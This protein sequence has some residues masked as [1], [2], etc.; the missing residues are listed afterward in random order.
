MSLFFFVYTIALLIVCIGVASICGATYIVTHSRR[1]LP[2]AGFFIFYFLELCEI[3][4]EEWLYHNV[5]VV[6]ASNYYDIY[7]PPLRIALGA[8]IL[9]C[10][11]AVVLNM[12]DVR[13]KKFIIYPTIAIV[14][15]QTAILL[16]MPYGPFRQWMFFTMRQVSLYACLGYAYWLYRKSDDDVLKQRMA[17]RKHAL[18]IL[19]VLTTLVLIEDSYV[20]LVSEI[21]TE[22]TGLVAL[23]LSARNFSENAMMLYL[24][25]YVSREAIRTLS[26]RY[27]EPPKAKAGT[28]DEKNL[29]G[30]I[31]NR[32][33]RFASDHGLSE[34]E[35]EI[36]VLAIE[37][38][39]NREIANQLVLAEGTIKTHLH[40]IMKKCEVKNREELRRSFWAS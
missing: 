21:P 19:L 7:A 2:R 12:L 18:Q 32:L 20:I 11:W 15:A 9:A 14:V 36:L 23:F 33:P 10:F 1:Q 17:K 29:Q 5:L 39:S 30:H 8:A 35:R 34:R 22:N 37:G 6:D 31:E 25:W 28:A 26:L 40:N 24:A 4:A 13:D 16:F 27:N 38:K 3:F